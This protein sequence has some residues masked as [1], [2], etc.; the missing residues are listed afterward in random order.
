MSF[1]TNDLT[2]GNHLV[3][4]TGTTLYVD[5]IAGAAQSVSDTLITRRSSTALSGI[6]LS[7]NCA[8]DITLDTPSFTLAIDPAPA[9]KVN[10]DMILR[11][12][13]IGGRTINWPN[14]LIFNNNNTPALATGGNGIDMFNLLTVNSGATW[15]TRRV[16]QY[17]GDAFY[18]D[19]FDRSNASTLGTASNGSIWSSFPASTGWRILS[20]MASP[21]PNFGNAVALINTPYSGNRKIFS[22]LT[23]SQIRTNTSLIIGGTDSGNFMHLYF[24]RNNFGT[25][26]S[27]LFKFV[28]G[29]ETSLTDFGNV[30]VQSFGTSYN[31]SVT[32]VN[33]IVNLYVN[34]VLKGNYTMSTDENSRFG[35]G[36]T[37]VGFR[38]FTDNSTQDDGLSSWD[39]LGMLQQ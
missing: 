16:F 22:I 14:S 28:S 35:T 18:I 5:G 9:G 4:V 1:Q 6:T 25:N 34:D 27:Q 29:A 37:K 24:G 7:N 10:F 11:Q 12:D 38:S 2:L 31:I 39:N 8:L 20:N 32:V 17:A 3:T 19:T 33:S 26:D 30:G 13:T 23:L 36:I 21:V 15:Y